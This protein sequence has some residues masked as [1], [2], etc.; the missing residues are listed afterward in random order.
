MIAAGTNAARHG[1]NAASAK[2]QSCFRALSGV[3]SCP[4]LSA[5]DR[6]LDAT[7]L[8]IGLVVSRYHDA[9]TDALRAGAME[10]FMRAGGVAGDLRVVE[11][12]GAFELTAVCRAL[13]DR[14]DIDGV[15]ALGCIIRGETS[16]DQHLAGAIA[17]GLTD[18]TVR[19]GV[20]IAFGVLTCHTHHQARERAGGEHGNKGE[21]AM[22][23]V[24]G[25]IHVIRAIASSQ[26][27]PV[28]GRG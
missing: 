5:H 23:A 9:V 10:V 3:P 15:V 21:E 7:G 22:A 24:I 8:R 17:N 1:T 28:R 11:A 18:I 2:R 25:T 26:G 12:P 27:D 6:N 14:P 16:H 19:T 20:P 4:M 13:A